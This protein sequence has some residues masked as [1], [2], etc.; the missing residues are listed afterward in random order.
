MAKK[1][2]NALDNFADLGTIFGIKPRQPR[3]EKPRK[4]NKCGGKLIK[5][6]GTNVYVCENE[7]VDKKS[8]RTWNHIVLSG[9][10]AQV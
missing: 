2:L 1:L 9:K 3:P 7:Q 5:V 6:K 4:C 8:G 10:S